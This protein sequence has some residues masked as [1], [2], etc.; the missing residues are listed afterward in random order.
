MLTSGEGVR[1]SL[2][3]PVACSSSLAASIRSLSCLV[4]LGQHRPDPVGHLGRLLLGD[5][6]LVDQLA[7]EQLAHRRV[8]LDHRVH[9]GLRVG[10]LVGLVVAEAAVA[11]QVD[12]H[13]VAELLAEGEGQPHGGDAGLDVVGVDVDD[14][15]VEALGQVGGQRRRA[16]VIGVGG[17][18]DLVV[19]DDVDRAADGVAV[20]RLE[21]ERLRDDALA[22]ERGVAVQDDRDRGVGVLVGVRALAGGLRRAGG[23]GDDGVDELQVRWVGLQPHGD[24]LA[25]QQ[26]VGALGAVV[27]LDVAGPA[28]G[29]RGDRLERLGALELGEDRPVRAAE[30]VREHVEPA[31]VGHPDDDLAGAARAR[32]LDELVDHRHGHIQALDRELLLAQVGLVHEALERVDLG[33][34]RSSASARRW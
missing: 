32:E 25:A 27:V 28:L 10:G 13:V 19:L 33:E 5:H 15:D 16:G 30:V 26:L 17:E 22:G 31:A 29:D 23:A 34:A 7:G 11:D 14:R 3:S 4:V 8:L 24:R 12:Q 1:S 2:Y 20:E 9:L 18:A 21:V 6:A